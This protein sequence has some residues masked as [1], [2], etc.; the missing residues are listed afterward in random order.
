MIRAV[1]EPL[2]LFLVPFAVFGAVLLF[3]RRDILKVE[4]WSPHALALAV[5]GLL[6][7]AGSLVWAGVF[8]ER[9]T[10][11]FEPTHLENGR[12]VPGRFR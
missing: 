11:Q 9:H 7:V 2:L 1:A 5:A 4:T 10:G 3:L 6:L 8:G 12:V